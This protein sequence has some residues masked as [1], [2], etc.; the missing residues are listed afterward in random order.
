MEENKSKFVTFNCQLKLSAFAFLLP[1][2]YTI[3]RYFHDMEYYICE[4]KKS[5][6]ILKYNLAYLIYLFLPKIFSFI[7]ILIVKS[8]IKGESFS[9]DENIVI[10]NYHIA[11]ENRNK[12]KYL[13][14]I[15]IIKSEFWKSE[16]G[17]SGSES[18]LFLLKT[19][20]TTMIMINKD[21]HPKQM[22]PK[23]TGFTFAKD[24][25]FP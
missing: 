12:K 19:I 11:A 2:L 18:F 17:L 21:I 22:K 1:I 8:N 5:L 7:F 20:G 13:L 4:P 25:V 6:K 23:M 16:T 3:I 15:Y 14:L 10:K 24:F 9:S